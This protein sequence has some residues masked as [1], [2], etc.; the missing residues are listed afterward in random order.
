MRRRNRQEV[1]ELSTESAKVTFEFIQWKDVRQ[2]YEDYLVGVHRVPEIRFP[3]EPGHVRQ[4]LGGKELGIC[5]VPGDAL[6]QEVH[7][8]RDIIFALNIRGHVGDSSKVN[9]AIS[10]S[11]GDAESA[12]DFPYLNNGVTVLCDSVRFTEPRAGRWEVILDNPQ[13]VNG[14]QTAITLSEHVAESRNVRVMLKII[15]V[16]RTDGTRQTYEAFVGQVVRATNF[17][18]PVP[19]QDF[20][21]NDWTQVE[22]ERLLHRAGHFYARKTETRGESRRKAL[23]LPIV[24]R[25]E[26]GDASGGCLEESLPYR[27]T[28]D[29]LYT[30][31]YYDRVFDV[32]AQPDQLLM[33][34]YLWRAIQRRLKGRT[35]PIDRKRSQWLV[36]Y[37]MHRDTRTQ[38]R[39]HAQRVIDDG[40][41]TRR[42]SDLRPGLESAI[43]A[44]AGAVT[45]F[46]E[47][48]RG[49]TVSGRREPLPE[50]ATNF[51]KVLQLHPL[52]TAFLRT[53]EGRPHAQ[54]TRQ[55]R[56]RLVTALATQA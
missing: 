49:Q 15:E 46:F 42:G 39:R 33:K 35:V 26:L 17:Q 53:R 12:R 13:I 28:K 31:Q 2:V 37:E 14:Q 56:E 19:L 36:L 34:V 40:R 9:A 41:L 8:Y 23:G 55:A 25:A 27:E 50:D 10:A 4:G 1:E 6:A 45:A 43:D 48:Y 11:L 32:T 38:L 3:M 51:F 5:L 16:K 22:V 18:T 20:H 52:F 24:T 54:A 21:S 44:Y 29:V 47:Q 7:R 30:S